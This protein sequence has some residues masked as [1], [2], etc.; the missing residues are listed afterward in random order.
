MPDTPVNFDFAVIGN[1]AIAAL[2]DRN[3][4]HQWCCWSRLD[5]D[6]VFHGLLSEDL[7][8]ATADTPAKFWGNFPQTY[9]QV[10]LIL[11]ATRLSRSGED[12]LWRAS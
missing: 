3:A 7:A 6:P 12:G 5:G 10:G 9:S 4:T 11:C 1:G 2:I 8:P